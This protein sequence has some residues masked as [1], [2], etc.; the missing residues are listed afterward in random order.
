MKLGKQSCYNT[1]DAYNSAGIGTVAC[2]TPRHPGE[3]VIDCVI[4]RWLFSPIASAKLRNDFAGV[5][6]Y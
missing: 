4:T 3:R 2:K 6:L 5:L 1:I